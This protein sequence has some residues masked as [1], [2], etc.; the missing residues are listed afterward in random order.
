MICV[1]ATWR[2]FQAI[3]FHRALNLGF[4]LADCP[5]ESLNIGEASEQVV[6]VVEA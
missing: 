6:G 4:V 3:K 5:L 1:M 2:M